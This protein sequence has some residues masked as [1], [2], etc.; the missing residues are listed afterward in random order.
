MPLDAL[1]C[2]AKKD[3]LLSREKD[4]VEFEQ[5]S[6]WASEKDTGDTYSNTANDK[7]Y[8]IYLS[9]YPLPSA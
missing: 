7:M 1:E 4:M 3:D 8:G 9:K 2:H 6:K 5:V